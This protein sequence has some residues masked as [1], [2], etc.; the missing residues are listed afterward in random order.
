MGITIKNDIAVHVDM[1]TEV[2]NFLLH[3]LIKQT[4]KGRTTD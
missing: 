4:H 3:L 1:S 2:F